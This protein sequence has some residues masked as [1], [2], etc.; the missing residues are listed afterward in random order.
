MD[1]YCFHCKKK[2][3]ITDAKGHCSEKNRMMIMGK[4]SVC[5]G[6][7]SRIVAKAD[8]VGSGLFSSLFSALKPTLVSAGKEALK[9]SIQEAG[10]E[11]GKAAGQAIGQKIKGKGK[12]IGID[13]YKLDRD[14][15]AYKPAAGKGI[16]RLLKE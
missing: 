3:T 13:V 8:A 12:P 16:V 11:V 14:K 9:Q 1:C 2:T 6:K 15:H 5:N 4:C 10:K 7:V